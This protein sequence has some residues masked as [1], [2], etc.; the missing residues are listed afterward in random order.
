MIYL[1]RVR[2]GHRPCR[3]PTPC[4]VLSGASH[5]RLFRISLVPA[6]ELVGIIPVLQTRKL[7]IRKVS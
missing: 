4:Q 2:G 6:F 1:P 3:A 7:S 5:H